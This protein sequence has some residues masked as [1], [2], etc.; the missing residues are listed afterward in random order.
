[1]LPT[2]NVSYE[3]TGVIVGGAGLHPDILITASDR[4]PVVIEAEYDPGSSVEDD[5]RARL[6]L[7]VTD[8][9]RVIESAIALRY[10]GALR[11]SSDLDAEVRNARFSYAVL[12][13]YGERFPESGWLEGSREDVADMVRLVSVPQRSVNEASDQ[14]ERGIDIAASRLNDMATLRP[15]ITPEI[16]KLLGLSDVLQTRRM[17]CAIVANAFVFHNRIAGMHSDVKQL[18]LVCGPAVLNPHREVLASWRQILKINYWA[19]IRDS[20][21]HNQPTSTMGSGTDSSCLA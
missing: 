13:E 10:A 4:A 5:A 6:G 14:L 3:D 16:A 20:R 15:F 8:G 9:N 21:G 2:C 1:M 19:D 11:S 17:A 12:Y 7:V 18:H